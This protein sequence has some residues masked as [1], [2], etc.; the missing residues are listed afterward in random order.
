MP[1]ELIFEKEMAEISK[2]KIME[3]A[4]KINYKIKKYVL[5]LNWKRNIR[6]C[7][8]LCYQFPIATFEYHIEQ[9]L[10]PQETQITSQKNG[11]SRRKN[12]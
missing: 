10:F 6:L 1:H 2:K 12:G 8:T 5:I 7:K 9:K 3:K 4:K 11:P